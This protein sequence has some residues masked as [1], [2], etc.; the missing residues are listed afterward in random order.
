MAPGSDSGAGCCAAGPGSAG[1]ADAGLR[2]G[3]GRG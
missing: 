1:G 3:L 2:A